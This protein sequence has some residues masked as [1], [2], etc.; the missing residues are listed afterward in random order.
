MKWYFR[1]HYL[2]LTF[3]ER[4]YVRT[5]RKTDSLMRERER[6]RERERDRKEREKGRRERE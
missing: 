6:E 4:I 3:W 2:K 1:V 5:L